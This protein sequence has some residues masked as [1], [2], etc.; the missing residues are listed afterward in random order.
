MIKEGKLVFVP[1]QVVLQK[2]NIASDGTS[3]VSKWKKFEEP[4]TFLVSDT[5][6][7]NNYIGVIFQNETWYVSEKEI[8][9]LLGEEADRR[10]N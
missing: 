2:Y 9:P 5:K 8:F 6:T 10:E 3:A 7:I 4:K 1:S